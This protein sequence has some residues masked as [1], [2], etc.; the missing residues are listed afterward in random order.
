MPLF[1]V[2]VQTDP[3]GTVVEKR[4]FAD[5]AICAATT[6]SMLMIGVVVDVREVTPIHCD[7]PAECYLRD[8]DG[9]CNKLDEYAYCPKPDEVAR[10]RAENATLRRL[11]DDQQAEADVLLKRI[12]E[13]EEVVE[14][15]S[16]EIDPGMANGDLMPVYVRAGDVRAARAAL[17]KPTE[18]AGDPG[19]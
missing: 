15:L 6:I 12:A 8:E 9:R 14:P 13:L 17:S 19:A 4:I 5:N 16:V 11:A 7:D 1:V 3:S 2:G 10:L 18:D